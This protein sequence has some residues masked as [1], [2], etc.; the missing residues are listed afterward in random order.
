MA[1]IEELLEEMEDILADGKGKAFS[2]RMTVDVDALKTVIED[3][4]LTVPEEVRQAR[5]LAS[6]RR[7]IMNRANKEATE[8]L[9]KAREKSR[10][11][12]AASEKRA[13]ENDAETTRRNEA[14]IND[15]Q[16][17]AKSIIE[18]AR[19]EAGRLVAGE[20]VVA[21]ARAAADS[22]TK[23]AKLSA[24]NLT[25]QAE[26]ILKE[27]KRKANEI[28][29]EAKDKAERLERDAQAESKS[30]MDAAVKWSHD[31][32]MSA[33]SYVEELV[34]E[35]EYRVAKSLNEIQKLQ[36]SL[37]AAAKKSS[38]SVKKPEPSRNAKP[39][40]KVRTESKN[41]MDEKHTRNLHQNE[42]DAYGRKRKPLGK[43]TLVEEDKNIQVIM[44]K[45]SIID[46]PLGDDYPIVEEEDM[47][48]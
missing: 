16:I 31:L 36:D 9:D 27:A 19:V 4:R 46:V 26:D 42:R 24:D 45:P 20:N 2:N 25:G 5:I 34:N 17:K 29:A 40:L 41:G 21:E 43:S 13:R 39:A 10:D 7:E 23:E 32:K 38:Q 15:A 30:T 28:V 12:L 14:L 47:F 6:E 11:L 3:I 33:G 22:I 35:T 8:M 44:P 48:L 18:S 37:T 1:Q